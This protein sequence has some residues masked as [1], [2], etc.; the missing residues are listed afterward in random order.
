MNPAFVSHP[1]HP[2]SQ[3]SGQ[4]PVRNRRPAGSNPGTFYYSVCV[5]FRQYISCFSGDFPPIRG[6]FTPDIFLAAPN[7]H[8][9]LWDLRR[10]PANTVSPPLSAVFSHIHSKTA[11]RGFKSFCPCQKRET[12]VCLS[13]FF[14]SDW[15]QASA[16]GACRASPP[17]RRLWRMQRGGDGAAVGDWQGGPAAADRAGY[18][19]RA[20]EASSSPSLHFRHAMVETASPSRLLPGFLT[21]PH[22][23]PA[24]ATPSSTQNAPGFALFG[25]FQVR[26]SLFRPFW[27]AKFP[28][29]FLCILPHSGHRLKPSVIPCRRAVSFLT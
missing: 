27:G 20:C 1:H 11:C 18:R 12:S 9:P 14:R 3:G 28:A 17:K 13:L 22:P 21:R 4:P 24:A 7:Q 10:K 6:C 25:H 16:R 5:G 19:K 29:P 8:R 26:F 2:L 15:G 23:S